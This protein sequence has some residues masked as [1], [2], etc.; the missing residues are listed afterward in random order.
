MS[1]VPTSFIVVHISRFTWESYLYESVL[2]G[3][4]V[5]RQGGFCDK[6]LEIYSGGNKPVL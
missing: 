6:Q 5:E 4:F 3:G 2:D 1:S